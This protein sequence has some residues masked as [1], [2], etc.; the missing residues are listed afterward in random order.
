MVRTVENKK[1]T[2][3]TQTSIMSGLIK[4]GKLKVWKLSVQPCTMTYK[5]RRKKGWSCQ[6]RGNRFL[7][8]LAVIKADRR[9]QGGKPLSILKNAKRRSR[10]NGFAI[11]NA[12]G[13]SLVNQ[14]IAVGR[15]R[16]TLRHGMDLIRRIHPRADD[17]KRKNH[18][19]E[20]NEIPAIA[21]VIPS[22]EPSHCRWQVL[23]CIFLTRPRRKKNVRNS[24]DKGESDG[25]QRQSKPRRHA[26]LQNRR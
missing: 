23:V 19:R 26:R 11:L 9:K 10:D 24:R 7:L 2:P 15:P 4:A 14:S 25:T 12:G 6:I 22:N 17:A 5:S 20:V 8:L 18:N 13:E 1:R 3:P 16:F 21:A